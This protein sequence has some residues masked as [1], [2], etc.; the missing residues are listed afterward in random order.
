SVQAGVRAVADACDAFFLVLADHSPPRPETLR[1]MIDALGESQNPIVLPSHQGR[2]GHPILISSKLA[3]EILA[4]TFEQTLASIVKLHAA[5]A[6]EVIVDDPAILEDIDT[7][8]DYNRALK[9]WKCR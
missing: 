5:D 4:L 2:H 6:R 8:E 9:R 7:P 1:T 3:P